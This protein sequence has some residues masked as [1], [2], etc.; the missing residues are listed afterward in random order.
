[1]PERRD[2][3]FGRRKGKPLSPRRAGL[4]ATELPKLAVDTEVTPPAYL[5]SLFPGSPKSLRLEIGFGG[6]EHLIACAVREPDAG[7]IGVEPFVAGMAKAVAAIVDGGIEN[8]RLY[9]GEASV[10]LDWLPPASL[11]SVDILYPDPWPKKRHWK[12]RF[13]SAE[14][15][16]RLARVLKTGGVLRFA[17]DIPSYV[18]WTLALDARREDFAWTA[19]RAADWTTPFPG[20]PGTRYEAKALTAGRTPTYLTFRRI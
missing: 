1:M 3:L 2:K 6:G 15:L 9:G 4:L 17:S 20:W 14:N 16:D 19:E 12:R 11:D 18:A 5:A 7:F 8:I 10:L 13:V